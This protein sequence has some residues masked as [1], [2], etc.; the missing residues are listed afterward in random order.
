MIFNESLDKTYG[1]LSRR[2]VYHTLFWLVFFVFLMFFGYQPGRSFGFILSNELLS[3]V[4]FA[5]LVYFNL[6]YLIPRYLLKKR[7][8][9]YLLLLIVSCLVISPIKTFFFYLKLSDL[10][11][12]QNHLLDNQ[13]IVFLGNLLVAFFST[14]LSILSGWWRFQQQNQQLETQ[15]M[16]NELRF[17]KSQINP[18]FL[19]NTLNNLFALTLKKD[20]RAPE[21]VLKLSE[22]MRYMLYECNDRTVLLTKEI[23]YM[24]NYLDLERL[25]QPDTVDISLSVEGRVSE[26]MIA[27]LLFIP[28]LENAFKHG[29]QNQ[30]TAGG[31]VRARLRVQDDDLEFYIENSKPAHTPKVADAGRRSG[32]IGLVNVRQRLELLYPK[33]H[34][35]HIENDPNQYAVTL[36]LKM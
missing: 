14:F 10:Q 5:V 31:F 9:M 7:V 25:R 28:F 33:N 26:Q 11:N 19:F 23:Q 29:V 18:H 17:L 8:L 3:L 22:I 30:I 16:Q 1:I 35:L 20:S 2:V 32:G 24:Q 21:I 12:L 27:P 15:T 4:L 34:E 6:L 13:E 36:L